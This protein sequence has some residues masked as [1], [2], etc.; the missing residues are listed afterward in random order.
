MAKI[1]TFGTVLDMQRKPFHECLTWQTDS[2]RKQV[3]LFVFDFDFES[4]NN[5]ILSSPFC[6]SKF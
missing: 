2:K 1:V 6:V 4:C 5:L 3:Q